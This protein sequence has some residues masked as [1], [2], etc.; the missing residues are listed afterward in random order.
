MIAEVTLNAL[1]DEL[2][3]VQPYPGLRPF[4]PKESRYF[5]GR[6]T[7]IEEIIQ[8][9]A[10]DNCVVILGGSGCGKSSIVRAGV[11][12][13]LRLKMLPG[14]SDF[15]RVA[16]CSP[17]RAP[18]TNLVD[19]LDGLLAPDHSGERRKKIRDML[20]GSD[21]LGGFLPAFKQDIP[22]GPGLSE[23]I[24]DKAN[25]LVLVEQFEELFREENR[26]K[27]EAADF[28]GFI[29]DAWRRRNR[30]SGFY[31]V[32]TMRTDDLHRCAE[33][34][35]LPD[36]INACGYLTRRLKETELR[37]AIVEPL[38]PAMFRAELLK[39][40][41]PFG[42]VDVRPYDVQVV[43]ELLDAVEEIAHDP[44][45]LPLLQHLLAVLW[46]TSLERWQREA[47]IRPEE[48]E[49]Q[50]TLQDLARAL[51]RESWDRVV[52]ERAV[53]YS[54]GV[55]G[56]LLRHC[57]G[58]VAEQLYSGSLYGKPLTEHQR[59]IARVAFRLMGEVDD[60]GNFTR[61]WTS[62]EEIAHVAGLKE[63][64]AD[65]EAVIHRFHADHCLF[66]VRP[67]G[68]IDVSHESLMRNWPLL[69]KYLEE[70]RDAGTAYR[71]LVERYTGWQQWQQERRFW[72]SWLT[73]WFG[74][75]HAHDLGR[76]K[77]L[78]APRYNQYWAK[79]FISNID[80]H[81]DVETTGTQR[82]LIIASATLESA[83]RTSRRGR[84]IN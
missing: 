36:F 19:A 64:N 17:G 81:R 54:A 38:R 37:Q 2:R 31:L 59:E 53:A 71:Y 44:D 77:Q 66:S 75:I 65:V 5:K 16:I 80:R 41:R 74:L 39:E 49:P 23:E 7:Q 63:P 9:L 45:H 3:N 24:L 11:I 55:R 26:G 30:Y 52:E 46:R 48:T 28:A 50:I 10:S 78:L 1:I 76:V 14:R 34:I 61:R 40:V 72:P 8:R 25:L 12:P 18:V 27:A 83:L 43:I 69:G 13:A 42:A 56:W 21:G 35:D 57:L 58:H 62:R 68:E 60:R 20:Y 73:K 79:R 4:E 47:N 67:S 22:L 51:G 32:L 33:F 6:E 29:I 82:A 70:D 84:Q 15:W